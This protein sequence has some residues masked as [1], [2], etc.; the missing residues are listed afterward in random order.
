MAVGGVLVFEGGP[1][2]HQDRILER[3]QARLHLIPK[4]RQRLQAPAGAGVLNPVWVDDGDFELSWHVRRAALTQSGGTPGERLS[5][6]V[7][8]EMS[9]KLDRSRPLWE[10]TVD[11][12]TARSA[13]SR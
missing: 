1:G 2:M 3:I 5:A 9:R 12:G 7:G 10:M 6:L 13:A 8:Q 11:R 4:Y